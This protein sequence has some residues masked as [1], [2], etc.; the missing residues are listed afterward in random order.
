MRKVYGHPQN[1]NSRYLAQICFQVLVLLQYT[2]KSAT[3]L[4]HL[5]ILFT[6]VLECKC[7]FCESILIACCIHCNDN[8]CNNDK[9]PLRF[10]NSR[11]PEN[12]SFKTVYM[13]EPNFK[14]LKLRNG[15]S[16][17]VL[18]AQQSS[19]WHQS[20]RCTYYFPP[21]WFLLWIF[22]FYTNCVHNF[23]LNCYIYGIFST[24]KYT[25]ISILCK[26]R[27]GRLK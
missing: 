24:F 4:F 14:N 19:D 8:T 10:W 20:T 25:L 21:V 1:L 18:E 23:V 9:I 6:Q 7:T 13:C 22:I 26:C 27:K 11:S 2:W 3:D 16:Q 15:Q 12:H 5:H 17:H